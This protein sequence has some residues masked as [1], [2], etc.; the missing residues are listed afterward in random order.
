[1]LRIATELRNIC[2]NQLKRVQKVHSTE[3]FVKNCFGTLYLF[4]IFHFLSYKYFAALLLCVT[5]VVNYFFNAPKS[6]GTQY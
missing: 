4:F 6:L 5:S 1:M 3:T 2:R